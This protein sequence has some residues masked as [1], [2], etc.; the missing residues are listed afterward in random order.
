MDSLP[1]QADEILDLEARH[2]DLLRRLADLDKR[3]ERVL[4][5]C[6]GTARREAGGEEVSMAAVEVPG[7][8]DRPPEAQAQ[9]D[10][11]NDADDPGN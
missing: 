7:L 9:G 5:E 4:A 10:A 3:V 2:D 8:A 6:L 11:Q 1:F